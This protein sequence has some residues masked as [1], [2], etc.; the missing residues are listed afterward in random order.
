M[1]ILR[2]LWG[3]FRELTLY[4]KTKH[5]NYRMTLN[6]ECLS[7]HNRPREKMGQFG[8]LWVCDYLC[9]PFPAKS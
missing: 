3:N 4:F 6:L 9:C 8:F 1:L 7:L 5:W 2:S